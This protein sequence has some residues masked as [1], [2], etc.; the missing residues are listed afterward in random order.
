M[1]FSPTTVTGTAVLEYG[2]A[3]ILPPVGAISKHRARL[4]RPGLLEHSRL[5]LAWHDQRTALGFA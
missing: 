4:C 5:P 3:E 1:V 2:P